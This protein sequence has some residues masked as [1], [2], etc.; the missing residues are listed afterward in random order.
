M[1][2]PLKTILVT[3]CCGMIGFATTQ[4]LLEHNYKVIGIDCFSF[5]NFSH[6]LYQ[7]ECLDILKKNSNFNY[8]EMDI[9][10]T[11]AFKSL[12]LN[13]DVII[14]LAAFAGIT[15]SFEN[16]DKVLDNNQKGL[17]SCLELVKDNRDVK[18]IPLFFASSSSVYGNQDAAT[19]ETSELTPLSIYALSKKHNE[20]IAKMYYDLYGVSSIGLRFFTVYGPY[21]RGDM[22]VHRIFQSIDYNALLTLHKNGAMKR[23]F[24]F[25]Q[26]IA[27][28]LLKFVN[29]SLS[30]RFKIFDIYNLGSDTN[31]DLLTFISLFENEMQKKANLKLSPTKPIYEPDTTNCDNSKILKHFPDIQFTSF[32]DGVAQTVQWYKNLQN[33]KDVN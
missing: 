15:Y 16:P 10:D 11:Q 1:N 13:P 6:H 8:I 32:E 21:N 20:D 24:T 27:Q 5:Y 29:T 23:S 19:T 7:K 4:L 25:N 26:D 30:T 12:N 33:I 28:I 9:S 3:G 22:L 31:I 18:T 2:T 14:H 17:I